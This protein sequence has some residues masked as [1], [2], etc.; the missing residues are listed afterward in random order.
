MILQ[1]EKCGARYAVP[2]SAVGPA[3]RTVRCAK[4]GHSWHQAPSA[5][6]V[7]LPDMDKLLGEINQQQT[8]EPVKARPIPQGSNLPKVKRKRVALSVLIPAAVSAAAALLM[9]AFI[10]KPGWFGLPRSNAI[11]LADVNMLKKQSEKTGTTYTIGGNIL[12]LD[13][14]TRKV[15][16][17]RITLVDKDGNSLKYWDISGNGESLDPKKHLSFSRE[18][19]VN[20]SLGD[21]FVVELGN[22]LELALRRKPSSHLAKADE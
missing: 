4:C 5:A 20:F 2:D 6:A 17:L 7:P 22:P 12:N 11:V 10:N 14:D 9:L 13:L 19:E 18:L 3:G 1:C 8:G 21:R 15:P 16:N